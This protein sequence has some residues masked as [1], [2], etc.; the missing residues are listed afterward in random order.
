MDRRV[1][2]ELLMIVDVDIR[3]WVV[4]VEE[5]SLYI[6]GVWVRFVEIGFFW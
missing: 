3:L 4:W 1:K 5:E 2:V 6:Y